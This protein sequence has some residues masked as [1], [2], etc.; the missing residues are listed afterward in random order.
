MGKYYLENQNKERL[1]LQDNNHQIVNVTGLGTSNDSKYTRVG[2]QFVN[3]YLS[4]VQNELKFGVVF[5]PPRAFDKLQAMSV[6]LNRATDLYLV[7]VPTISKP[8]EYRRD[9]DV[10]SFTQDTTVKGLLNYNMTIKCKSLFYT[11]EENSFF[12]ERGTGEM[13]YNYSFPARFNDNAIRDVVIDND[14]H[15]DA[16]FTV[17]LLG[18]TE[19]PRIIVFV[20]G[21]EKYNLS[22]DTIVN[23]GEKIIYSSRDGNLELSHI[24]ADGT[25][26]NIIDIMD[27]ETETFFKLPLGKV[28]I[29]FTS[30]T[31]TIGKI[32]F[33]VYKYY[34]VV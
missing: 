31:G 11:N 30:D 12:V 27:F 29:Q 13:R 9:I 22:F 1:D 28:K 18:Y 14:G 25:I 21:V 34:K 33:N 20:D 5:I 6:F 7:Y 23:V 32:R 19:K 4:M 26:T 16:P 3:D 2:Y 17:E 15:V 10:V 8:Q 24:K